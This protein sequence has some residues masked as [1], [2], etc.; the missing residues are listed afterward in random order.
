MN[1]LIGLYKTLVEVNIFYSHVVTDDYFTLCIYFRDILQ[2]CW[3]FQFSLV[4]TAAIYDSL[5]RI[6]YISEQQ[7]LHTQA[8]NFFFMLLRNDDSFFFFSFL[9]MTTLNR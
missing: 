5:I 9:W 1:G 7:R 2:Q 6:A 8:V 4:K 3:P